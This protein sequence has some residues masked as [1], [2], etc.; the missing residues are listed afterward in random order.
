MATVHGDNNDLGDMDEAK[1]WDVLRG[2]M[3]ECAPQLVELGYQHQQDT[4]DSK[5]KVNLFPKILSAMDRVQQIYI[6]NIEN[7]VEFSEPTTRQKVSERFSSI[8]T[9]SVSSHL[10]TKC[11]AERVNGLSAFKS[12]TRLIAAGS[13]IESW[14]KSIQVAVRLP[15]YRI[16]S[17]L[18]QDHQHTIV[19]T[20]KAQDPFVT[21]TESIKDLNIAL[22]RCEPPRLDAENV[23]RSL[24]MIVSRRFERAF[25][26]V[27][28]Y[29]NMDIEL[30]KVVSHIYRTYRDDFRFSDATVRTRLFFLIRLERV[31]FSNRTSQEAFFL[32]ADLIKTSASWIGYVNT[33]MPLL[34]ACASLS[35]PRRSNY[36]DYKHFFDYVLGLNVDAYHMGLRYTICLCFAKRGLWPVY[37]PARKTAVLSKELLKKLFQMLPEYS[38]KRLF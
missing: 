23:A 32:L 1:A 19:E 2:A 31:K 4:M 22:F 33:N 5:D 28:D 38:H 15:R 26:T 6:A 16:P 27:E 29:V 17:V 12:V 21:G 34:F 25:T 3:R 10:A 37:T 30:A 36:V 14:A 11:E 20:I 8:V 7:S 13:F 18:N 9:S 35:G 24:M